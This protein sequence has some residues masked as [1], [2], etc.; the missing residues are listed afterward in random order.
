MLLDRWNAAVASGDSTRVSAL[1]ESSTSELIDE[2]K[3]AADEADEQETASRTLLMNACAAGCLRAVAFLL[4][5]CDMQNAWN[6]L[7]ADGR[8]AGELIP[9]EHAD[10]DQIEELL[11]NAA[12]R[13][14]LLLGAIFDHAD[15]GRTDDDDDE[16]EDDD[17]DNDNDDGKKKAKLSDAAEAETEADD[18]VDS[19]RV[20]VKPPNVVAR[21]KFLSTPLRYETGKD[22]LRLMTGATAT[23]DGELN[24]AVMMTWETDIM[25]MHVDRFLAHGCKTVLNVGFGCGIIDGQ[26]EKLSDDEMEQHFII[27]A[28][29]DV[30]AHMRANGWFEKPRVTVLQGTWQTQLPALME[31]GVTFD[32]VFFDTFET[33][34]DMR[35]FH[36]LLVNVL[37]PDGLYSFF[38]GLCGTNAFFHRVA[39]ALAQIQ[40]SDMGFATFYESIDLAPLQTDIFEGCKRQYFNLSKYNLP[41]V[42]FQ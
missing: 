42:T 40:L 1:I 20:V 10:R 39:C 6:K 13:T 7:D 30:L 31:R 4:D 35:E 28:H 16:D 41:H 26:L 27:E 5:E 2:L 9:S 15:Y 33:L 32:C 18:G 22:G 8:C 14:E 19:V 36:D 24:D 3:R 12:C 29:P 34:E 11:V 37:A 23:S 38:N 25:Q 17:N 21:E